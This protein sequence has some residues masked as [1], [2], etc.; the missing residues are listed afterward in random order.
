MILAQNISNRFTVGD[1]VLFSSLIELSAIAA[2][3]ICA[4]RSLVAAL[5]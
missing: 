1:I 4:V 2:R 3:L 5:V